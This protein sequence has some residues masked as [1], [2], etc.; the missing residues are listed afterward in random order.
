MHVEL[1]VTLELQGPVLTRATAPGLP[2]LDSP[3]ARNAAGLP[4]LPFSLVQGWLRQAWREIGD[5]PQVGVNAARLQDLL[6]REAN[7]PA[8]W[9]P[10]PGRLSFSDFVADHQGGSGIETSVSLDDERRAAK[11]GALRHLEIPFGAGEKISFTGAI[12]FVSPDEKHATEIAD[13]IEMGLRW[14]PA[15]GADRTVGFGRAL[16]LAIE[17]ESRAWPTPKIEPKPEAERESV[18]RLSL[19]LLFTDPFCL[20]IRPEGGN[21]FEGSEVVPGGVLKGTLARM[22]QHRFG[23]EP[24]TEIA[25]NLPEPF[26][27]L[28]WHF[29][30]LRFTHAF[31]CLE[32]KKRPTT[33]PLSTVVV[34]APSLAD[35][36]F[37]VALC[38]DPVLIAGCAPAFEPDWKDARKQIR[39]RLGWPELERDLRVR[40]K[41]EPKHRRAED[42]KLFALESIVPGDHL[43]RADVDLA[44]VPETDRAAVAAQL[45]ALLDSGLLGVGKTAAAAKVVHDTAAPAGSCTPVTAGDEKLWILTLQ[46]PTLLADPLSLAEG[47]RDAALRVAYEAAWHDLSGGQLKLRRFFAQQRL[48]GGYQ[49]E[50]FR[51]QRTAERDAEKSYRP[52]FLTEAGSVFVL[53]APDNAKA[54][55]LIEGWQHHGLPLPAWAKARYGESWRGNPFTRQDGYG[56]IAVNLDWHSDRRP[57]DVE[58]LR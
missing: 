19:S 21:L 37:D 17:R 1:K 49:T 38:P 32:D 40:T 5:L 56:E 36:I 25:G 2:G 4:I 54:A 44:D 16:G 52:Y 7:D 3:V 13:Q 11:D 39:G 9:R 26:A 48:A 47:P 41:I 33:V 27:E 24:A 18:G 14:I 12:R 34:K 29:G 46:T 43:W 51:R 58:E 22:L 15:F 55:T 31:P 28:G 8:S 50:R 30:A 23:L 35:P 10:M 45:R 6:G 20:A 42:E 57:T 53:T